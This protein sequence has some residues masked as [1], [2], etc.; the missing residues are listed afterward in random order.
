MIRTILSKELKSF[1]RSP[2]AYI[3]AGLFALVMGWMFFNQLVYFAENTQKLPLNMR[4]EYD[5]ANSVIIKLFGSINF[6]ILF[7]T[8]IL[9]MKS[10]SEEYKDRTIELYFSSPISDFELVIGKYLSTVIKG[11]FLISTTLI[12]PTFLGKIDLSDFSFVVTGYIGLI[13]NFSCFAVLGLLASSLTKNQVLAA[14][15]AFVLV[16]FSW[17]IAVFSQMTQNFMLTQIFEYLSINHHFENLAKGKIIL[18]DFV[19][20]ISFISF[21]LVLLKVRIGARK[22]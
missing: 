22:W 17:M 10:F 16:L 6:I 21:F 14:I 4:H 9:T 20:Y 2:M 11:I 3:M 7:L 1:F 12:L 19:F 18:S 13:L 5:F 15:I 8:P